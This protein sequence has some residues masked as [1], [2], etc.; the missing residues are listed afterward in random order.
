MYTVYIR[1]SVRVALIFSTLQFR[2]VHVTKR[3]I[4]RDIWPQYGSPLFRN[5]QVSAASVIRT[6]FFFSIPF[7]LIAYKQALVNIEYEYFIR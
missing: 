3:R 1:E 7:P 2:N 5:T 6:S 4:E